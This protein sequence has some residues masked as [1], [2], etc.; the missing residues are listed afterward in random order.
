MAPK[1]SLPQGYQ[2]RTVAEPV[3][4]ILFFLAAIRTGGILRRI[5]SLEVLLERRYCFRTSSCP[6]LICFASRETLRCLYTEATRSCIGGASQIVSLMTWIEL[7]REIGRIVSVAMVVA[8]L[9]ASPARS[10]SG[11]AE[12]PGIYWMK[13]VDGECSR[14]GWDEGFTKGL[15]V[16]AK[17][18][19][20]WMMVDVGEFPW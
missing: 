13:N 19:G 4:E 12:W 1:H 18:Y 14:M 15:T 11:M 5:K 3:K 8:S 6:L 2:S 9:A 20:G 10:L 16:C 7:D 17:E